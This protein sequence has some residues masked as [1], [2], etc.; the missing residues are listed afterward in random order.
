MRAGEE[1]GDRGDGDG[2]RVPGRAR[3][4]GGQSDRKG[5]IAEVEQGA[6]EAAVGGRAGD[7]VVAVAGTVGHGAGYVGGGG[8]VSGGRGRRWPPHFG[9]HLTGKFYHLKFRYREH[10]SGDMILSLIP[11]P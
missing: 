9:D 10:D 3:V 4:D 5:L 7:A 2:L 1:V 11:L 6:F 8:R